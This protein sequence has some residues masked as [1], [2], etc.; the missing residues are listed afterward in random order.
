MWSGNCEEIFPP[1]G[2]ETR[3][4]SC[5]ITSELSAQAKESFQSHTNSYK[6]LLDLSI[7]IIFFHFFSPRILIS[8]STTTP[9]LSSGGLFLPSGLGLEFL[10]AIVAGIFERHEWHVS[11]CT[12]FRVHHIHVLSTTPEIHN[13]T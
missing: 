7:P 8:L 1:L 5:N 6:L 9:H 2:I 10:F 11:I 4:P 12:H 3:C 13:C